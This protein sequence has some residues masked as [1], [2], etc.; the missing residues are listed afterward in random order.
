[1]W[2]IGLELM[3]T[4]YTI[5]G[6]KSSGCVIGQSLTSYVGNSSLA[7]LPPDLFERICGYLSLDHE[8]SRISRDFYN[9]RSQP[10]KLEASLVDAA[11]FVERFEVFCDVS[12]SDKRLVDVWFKTRWNRFTESAKQ[13]IIAK[14]QNKN[15]SLPQFDEYLLDKLDE[16]DIVTRIK[17]KAFMYELLPEGS[18]FTS[19]NGSY[20]FADILLGGFSC[21][22][23]SSRFP[24]YWNASVYA[25]NVKDVILFMI[26]SHKA[27][28]NPRCNTSEVLLEVNRQLQHYVFVRR[29][30]SSSFVSMYPSLM[31]NFLQFWFNEIGERFKFVYHSARHDAPWK[32]V[33]D[34]ELKRTVI[35]NSRRAR[36]WR[37]Y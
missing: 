7:V 21:Q 1:M 23:C 34:D 12:D 27:R 32:N 9:A 17:S 20:P 2:R 19:E 10:G 11:G 6:C 16:P 26:E 25:A 4:M 28:R 15:G 24:F 22:E 30:C 13:S 33:A 5:L 36:D 18:V 31:N 3:V 37:D 14:V 35:I 8:P 29:Y